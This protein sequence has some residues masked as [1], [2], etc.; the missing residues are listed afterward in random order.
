MLCLSGFELY[1]RWVPRYFTTNS[2]ES[3][4]VAVFP[5]GGFSLEPSGFAK[6][7]ISNWRYFGVYPWIIRF[8]L[9]FVF[10]INHLGL[11]I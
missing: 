1:S 4:I 10:N 8:S 9:P 3:W 6:L 11:Q 2:A 7:F 5:F